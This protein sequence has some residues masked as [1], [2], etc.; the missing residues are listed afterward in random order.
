MALHETAK[1]VIIEHGINLTLLLGSV[2]SDDKRMLN[3]SKTQINLL[4][5]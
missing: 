1:I 4:R 2:S 5:R 3:L